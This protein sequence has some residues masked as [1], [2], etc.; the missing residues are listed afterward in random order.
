V[1]LR[2]PAG[3]HQR[4]ANWQALQQ[5]CKALGANTGADGIF[6]QGHIEGTPESLAF[7]AYQGELLGCALAI[8]EETTPAGEWVA[9]RVENAPALLVNM[10]TQ[11]LATLRWTGGG[12]LSLIRASEDRCYAVGWR[13]GFPEWIFGAALAGKNLPAQLLER[14]TGE[15][16]I[17]QP[18]AVRAFARIMVEVPLREPDGVQPTSPH[19][20]QRAPVSVSRNLLQDA[21][22]HIPEA[23]VADVTASSRDLQETPAWLFL[24]GAAR[25][26]FL[27]AE[28]LMRRYSSPEL[29]VRVAYSVKT[30]PERRLL[31]LAHTSGLLAE[32]ISQAEVKK[33]IACGFPAGRIILNGPAKQW[34]TSHA[35][36]EPLHAVFCDSL[37]ELRAAV[38]ANTT[39]TPGIY[40]PEILGIRLRAPHFVSR[41][42]IPVEM[43]GAT[44]AVGALVRQLPLTSRF[45][46]HFHMGSNALGLDHWWRLFSQMLVSA[47]AIETTSGRHISCLDLGG[48]WYPDDWADELSPRFEE[49]VIQQVKRALPHVRELFLEPGRMLAQ[50]SMALAVRVLE[51][52]RGADGRIGDV[53][54][55]GSIAELAYHNYTIFPHRILW[56][57]PVE[58]R[59]RPVG[60]GQARILGRLCMEKDILAEAVDVPDS[61]AVGDLFAFC[62]AGAYDRSMSYSFG[63][64]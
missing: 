35:T 56:R 36:P 54:V 12:A 61:L 17:A 16:A 30:N 9:S 3:A 60:R 15:T 59:W 19:L 34:P 24:P 38:T 26:A 23:I 62:D 7:A 28:D 37:E 47:K 31:E 18:P 11:T 41:F 42:G 58:Q 21:T 33:A 43:A 14:V 29:R 13:I 39:G 63:Q 5:A 8:A 51:V 32:T 6:L 50:S 1:W 20:R 10:L 49:R 2:T 57:D 25:G 52:R 27:Q 55:D 48:G 40:Q 44:E 45:G 64:G 22:P 4:I 53:V 46:V